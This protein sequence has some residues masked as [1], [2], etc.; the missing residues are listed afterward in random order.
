MI[1]RAENAFI[2]IGIDSIQAVGQSIGFYAN[3]GYMSLVVDL[4]KAVF[5]G[6]DHGGTLLLGL[7]PDYSVRSST[8]ANSPFE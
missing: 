5:S 1:R 4:V 3:A 7:L 8:A 2:L 6:G